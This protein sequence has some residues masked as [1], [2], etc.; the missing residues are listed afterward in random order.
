LKKIPR[1]RLRDVGDAQIEEALSEPEASTVVA[2][3]HLPWWRRA[4]P[5]WLLADV[6]VIV[7][8]GQTIGTARSNGG[9]GIF[10]AR[11]LHRAITLSA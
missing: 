4:Y 8:A 7:A 1:R 9:V 2:V 11:K 10:T 3:S 5:L 6:L